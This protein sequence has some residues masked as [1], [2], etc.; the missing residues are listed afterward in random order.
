MRI[1]VVLAAAVDPIQLR[2]GSSKLNIP[3]PSSMSANLTTQEVSIVIA[4]Q[5]SPSMVREDLLKYSGIIPSTWQLSRPPMINDQ[6]SQLAFENGCSI[7]AQPD[8]IMFL[9]VMG[10]KTPEAVVI[11]EVARKYVETMKAATYQ[12]VGIN[13]RSFVPYPDESEADK[14]ICTK[15]LQSGPWQDFGK[16]PVK[17]ALNLLYELERGQLTLAI[18]GATMQ[19][20]D[21]TALPI[22]L[23]SGNFNY[24]VKDLSEEKRLPTMA[25]TIEN[26]ITDYDTFRDLITTKFLGPVGEN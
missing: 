7:A 22:L 15:F 11:G 20:G 17:A 19:Q 10:D 23:F 8:R 5:Q 4:A 16:Q 9:E 6:L 1:L 12:A 25:M 3:T 13:F 2:M 26:W 21:R 18:N 24:E 14:Y